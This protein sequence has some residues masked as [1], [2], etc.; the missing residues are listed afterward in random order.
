MRTAPL[1][2]AY[3]LQ[4]SGASLLLF[5]GTKELGQYSIASQVADVLLIVPGSVGLVL[6]PML[7]RQ[8]QDLWPRV[9]STV[10]LTTVAMLVLCIMAAVFAP[11]ILPLVFGAEYSRAAAALWGLLPSVLAYSI[12]SV[13]S[14][15]LVARHYPW[16]VVMAWVAGLAAALVGGA[17]LTS[18]YGAVGAGLSQSLGALLV[19]V[20]IV[21][22]AKQRRLRA[23]FSA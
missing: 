10:L 2:V 21:G 20:V 3:L 16:T 19:C 14:Q 17:M 22:I 12:V 5:A 11:L 9:R 4:R 15:Y 1:T 13:L 7:V 23:R 18:S 8:D 6:Y